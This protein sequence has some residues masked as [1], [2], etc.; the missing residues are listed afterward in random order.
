MDWWWHPSPRVGHRNCSKKRLS[1]PTD[2]TIHWKALEEHFLVV[3]LVQFSAGKCIFWVFLR[4]PQSLKSVKFR[5]L[6]IS[7]KW[8][9]LSKFKGQQFFSSEKHLHSIGYK[10][11]YVPYSSKQDCR[12]NFDQLRV[13]FSN[14][15]ETPCIVECLWT[16]F[17]NTDLE[18]GE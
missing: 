6:Q 1:Q 9:G 4:K 12:S 10:H 11:G 3:P 18:K 13:V 14:I 16:V 7:C 8:L 15:L 5:Y 2:M 17:V